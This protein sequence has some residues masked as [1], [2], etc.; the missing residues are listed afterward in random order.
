LLAFRTTGSDLLAG[1]DGSEESYRAA[2]ADYFAGSRLAAE[3]P[4][5]KL[6][7]IAFAGFLVNERKNV[8]EIVNRNFDLVKDATDRFA[9]LADAIRR[10]L[11]MLEPRGI[12]FSTAIRGA[13][14]AEIV[15]RINPALVPETV[16]AFKR[17][18]A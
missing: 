8:L 9:K 6:A 11:P 3:S 1:K 14:V 4:T 12:R 16:E 2:F 17:G 18:E 15:N 13:L 5:G 7:G 10:A